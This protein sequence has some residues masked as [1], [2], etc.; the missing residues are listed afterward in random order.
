MYCCIQC[1]IML[2]VY[3]DGEN[4]AKYCSIK[5]NGGTPVEPRVTSSKRYV[6]NS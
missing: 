2:L 3:S 1:D 6:K 4:Y 5:G